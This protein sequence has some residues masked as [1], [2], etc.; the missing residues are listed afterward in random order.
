VHDM[1]PLG[2]VQMTRKNVST[3]IVEAF[4]DQC[5][6]CEGRGILVHDVD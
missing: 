3:G 6:T 5:P 1:S 2:L 4:S